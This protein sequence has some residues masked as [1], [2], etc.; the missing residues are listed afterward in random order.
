MSGKMKAVVKVHGAPGAELAEVDIPTPG[1]NEVL[2]KVLATSICGTDVHIY[3][4][5]PWAQGRI[6]TP[7]I[8]GHELAG[9]VVEI[10]ADVTSI[11]VGDYVSAETHIVCGTCYQCRN[12]MA[13]ICANLKILGVDRD[14][15]FAEYVTIPAINAWRM[16]RRIPPEVASMQD[17]FGNAVHTALA[18]DLAGASVLVLGCGPTGLAAIGIARAC[19]AAPVIA[20]D[21]I[22]YRLDLAY[23]MGATAA[24]NPASEDVL[25]LVHD[26]T[27][28]TGVDVVMEMSGHPAAI[29]LGFNALRNGGQLTILGIPSR[30][31]ELDL[32]R[33]IVFKEARVV[34]ITGRLMFKTWYQADALLRNG[35]VDLKPIVTHRLPL[36]DFD[37]GM[38]LMN[39]GRCGK[40]VLYPDPRLIGVWNKDEGGLL[41]D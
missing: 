31:V 17:P 13:H 34:G 32:A 6:R 2:I 26:L 16:D 27:R 8:L 24:L 33:D 20:T 28:G 10:G 1:P 30:P 35:L 12:D 41:D 39:S 19:G 21:V 36:E 15:C 3:N 37:T 18:G 38:E 11:A 9:E 5:D 23:R 4:W 7:Q 25:A 29:K 14:G 40:V 22:D